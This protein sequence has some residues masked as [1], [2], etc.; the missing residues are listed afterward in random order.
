MFALRLK[1]TAHNTKS[2]SSNR[3]LL[4]PAFACCCTSFTMQ[5]HPAS[6]LKNYPIYHNY[7]YI[8][9][10]IRLS[11]TKQPSVA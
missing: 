4:Q 6:N 10:K 11:I 5:E 9:S 7:L 8:N 1:H 3:K 2:R